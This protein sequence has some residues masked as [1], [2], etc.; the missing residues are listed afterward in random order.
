MLNSP[1]LF[2]VFLSSKGDIIETH[3]DP[4]NKALEKAHLRTFFYV[5]RRNPGGRIDQKLQDGI[6]HSASA[7][8]I[9][10]KEYATSNWYLDELLLI[11]ER[12]RTSYFSIIPIYCDGVVFEDLTFVESGVYS[13]AF[14]NH[15]AKYGTEK[16]RMWKEAFKDVGLH[17]IKRASGYVTFPCLISL[18]YFPYAD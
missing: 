4:L 14:E 17:E 1:E 15:K 5:E 3:A 7:I 10:S 18:F 11:L 6:K 16:V 2:H 9:F 12:D 8:I 13:K